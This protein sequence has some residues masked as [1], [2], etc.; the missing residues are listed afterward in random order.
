[1]TFTKI[2]RM[3][4]AMAVS[5][6]AL[7]LTSCQEPLGR[8]VTTVFEHRDCQSVLLLQPEQDGDGRAFLRI[9]TDGILQESDKEI[10][11]QILEYHH[12][13]ASD[14]GS[15]MDLIV[16]HTNVCTS[17]QIEASLPVFG[18]EAGEDLSGF[19]LLDKNGPGYII[20]SNKELVG[21]ILG[22]S[23]A[24]GEITLSEWLSLSPLMLHELY[25]K[26]K[27]PAALPPGIVFTV[28]VTLDGE[29]E[30]EATATF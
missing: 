13:K 26:S 14:I 15:A 30:L 27:Q 24:H 29:K 2:K 16:Y 23:L 6:V 12:R 1:M 28:K 4:G 17:L 18:Q 9:R 20:K 25:L 8:G 3:I 21:S 5:V 7:L 11:S 19:F 10:E 22:Y